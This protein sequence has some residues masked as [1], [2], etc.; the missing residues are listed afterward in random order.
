MP[1][2]LSALLP[3]TKSPLII[4]A[5]MAGSATSELAIAV[6]RAGGLGQIGSA[7]DLNALDAEL[8]TASSHTDLPRTSA[9][10]LPIG[11]GMLLFLIKQEE[12]MAVLRKHRPAVIWLFAAKEVSD[13]ASWAQEARQASP[14][15]LV[16][17]QT[18]SV[19][20]AVTIAKEA[21]PDVL[22]V[23]GADAGG[24]GLAKSAGLLSLLPEVQDALVREGVEGVK[25]VG[26]GGTT[27]GRGAAAAFAL[28]AEGVVMGTRFLA[29]SETKIDPTWR[30]AVLQAKDGGR[31]TVKSMLFDELKG[32]SIWP[33]G[34]DGRGIANES[35]ADFEKGV[36]IDQVRKLYAEASQQQDKG[37][38]VGGKG[39]AAMWAGSGVGLVT[40]EQSAAAILDEVREGAVKALKVAGS[41]I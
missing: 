40:K 37:L 4:N 10:L 15:S 8:Q 13:Y 2:Q 41:M 3:W 21:K 1:S 6:T 26:S 14:G 35:S 17:V 39:R 33:Q 5:P 25:V 30:A 36:G 16:W 19:A 31:E 20:D 9:G 29:A 12:A 28:G 11:V 32:P 23:Q 22:V 18:G 7:N 38:G 27:D 24:H 34:Y